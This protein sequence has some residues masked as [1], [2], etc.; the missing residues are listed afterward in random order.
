ML[1]ILGPRGL[2]QLAATLGMRPLLAFDFDG[3]L[4]PIVA[5]PEQARM[6]PGVATRLKM[7]AMQLPVA[8]V[9]GRQVADVR[10][11]L[12]FEPRYIVGSHGAESDLG[13][14]G[15]DWGPA[16][17]HARDWLNTY[18]AELTRLG[19]RVEDKRNSI[20]LHYRLAPDR[21]LASRRLEELLPL[22][23]P[24]LHA[25]GGKFVCNIVAAK[26]P[27]KAAAVHALVRDAGSAAAIFVGDDVNDEPVFASAPASWV[28][29]K[30][31][32]TTAPSKARF[33]LDSPIEMASLLDRMLVLLGERGP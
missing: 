28:T 29:I 10:T 15:T 3:T 16:L 22:L 27:N 32:R 17:Q 11:R 9:T 5:R 1:Q 2:A 6:T 7:L 24:E 26:A 20:A 4:A 14:D 19:V 13:I 30:V 25:F 18:H 31:G 21:E 23:G 12:G 8:I 33:Y